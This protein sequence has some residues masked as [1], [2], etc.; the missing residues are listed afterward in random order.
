MLHSPDGTAVCA[1]FKPK[2]K[3]LCPLYDKEEKSILIVALEKLRNKQ[4][5]SFYAF[6]SLRVYALLILCYYV[7][8]TSESV[9]E[10]REEKLGSMSEIGID[11]LDRAQ[12]ALNSAQQGN[13]KIKVFNIQYTNYYINT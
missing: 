13:S 4:R 2:E 8:S 12:A 11:V 3:A 7:T 1:P 9:C 6:M 5:N 10:I